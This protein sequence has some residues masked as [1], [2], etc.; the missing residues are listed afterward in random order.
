[1]N[2]HFLKVTIE[3]LLLHFSPELKFYFISAWTDCHWILRDM[4]HLFFMTFHFFEMVQ[5]SPEISCYRDDQK[6]SEYKFS[7]LKVLSLK[8]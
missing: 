6:L 8:S 3:I 7:K 5:Q 1:M 4:Q 2:N